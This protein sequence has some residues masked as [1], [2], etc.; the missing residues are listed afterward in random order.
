LTPAHE[1]DFDR[2]VEDIC[3]LYRRAP[4][5]AEQG[6]RVLS[7]DELTGVQ[8]LERKTPNLP[9]TPGKVERREFVY[10]RHGNPIGS[11]AGWQAPVGFISAGSPTGPDVAKYRSSGSSQGGSPGGGGTASASV[12]FSRTHRFMYL[13]AANFVLMQE[14][15]RKNGAPPLFATGRCGRGHWQLPGRHPLA[16]FLP[17]GHLRAGLQRQPL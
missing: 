10:I 8:A 7:T 6:E 13:P 5:L 14:R 3:D 17:R 1:E 12:L 2:K 4:E 11:N 16:R 15:Q 9:L